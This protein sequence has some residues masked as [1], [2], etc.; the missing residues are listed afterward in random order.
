MIDYLASCLASHHSLLSPIQSIAVTVDGSTCNIVVLV[1]GSHHGRV[2]V[3]SNTLCFTHHPFMTH[4]VFRLVVFFFA[5]CFSEFFIH[6]VQLLLNREVFPPDVLLI[7]ISN[8]CVAV[9]INGGSPPH[10]FTNSPT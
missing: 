10:E 7:S 1:V 3:M 9:T 6:F 4:L 2:S 8:I 5:R